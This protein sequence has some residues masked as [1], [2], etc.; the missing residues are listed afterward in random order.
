MKEG[1][2]YPYAA[3]IMRMCVQNRI[4]DPVGMNRP[5]V[6][7]ADDP[8]RISQTLAPVAPPPTACLVAEKKSRVS[9]EGTSQS[10]EN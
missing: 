3:D 10:Q 4:F 8:R 9:S 7:D 6:L 1:K 2:H 5:V